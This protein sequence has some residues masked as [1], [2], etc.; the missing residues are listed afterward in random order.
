MTNNTRDWTRTTIS[1]VAVVVSVAASAMVVVREV[2][3]LAAALEAVT[4]SVDR[5]SNRVEKISERDS[6]QDAAIAAITANRYTDEDGRRDLQ[7]IQ[8]E[9]LEIYKRLASMPTQF[10]PPEH[11]R[12]HER[13]N[14][15]IRAFEGRYK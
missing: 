14:E 4:E 10:P 12:E 7:A 2:G 3:A 9:L 13:L 8:S 6:R 11:I 1:V 5:M 15:R